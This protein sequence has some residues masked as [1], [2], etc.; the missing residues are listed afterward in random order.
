MYFDFKKQFLVF[1]R[2]LVFIIFPFDNSW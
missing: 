2:S 1:S